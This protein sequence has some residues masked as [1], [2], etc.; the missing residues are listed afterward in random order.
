M[1]TAVSSVSRDRVSA[2]NRTHNALRSPSFAHVLN[3]DY[4]TGT[5][6]IACTVCR[7]TGRCCSCPLDHCCVLIRVHRCAAQPVPEPVPAE[8]L[9][10]CRLGVMDAVH[11]HKHTHTHDHSHY[12]PAAPAPNVTQQTIHHPVGQSS[13]HATPHSLPHIHT[14]VHDGPA[15]HRRQQPE[16]MERQ[17]VVRVRID[18]PHGA[19]DE[20]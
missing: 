3:G 6:T 18:A 15:V 7:G 4:S 17:I 5:Q 14:P 9:V 8:V 19:E 20:P 12:T 2:L 13:N 16:R 11:T 10:V 1:E